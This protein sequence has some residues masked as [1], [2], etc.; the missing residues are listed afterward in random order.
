MQTPKPKRVRSAK[1]LASKVMR[2]SGE[3]YTQ[4]I[5]LKSNFAQKQKTKQVTFDQFFTQLMQVAEA[6]LTGTEIYLVSGKAYSDLAEARGQAIIEA[7]RLQVPPVMPTV[8]IALGTDKGL[9]K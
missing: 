6:L 2:I 9:S 8:C 5:R 4:F 3:N 1:A 7:V